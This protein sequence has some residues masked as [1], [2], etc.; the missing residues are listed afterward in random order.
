MGERVQ[1]PLR[2][3]VETVSGTLPFLGGFLRRLIRLVRVV[4]ALV[5]VVSVLRLVFLP[6]LHQR[7]IHPITRRGVTNQLRVLQQ[8]DD[9]LRRRL[10]RL[11]VEPHLVSH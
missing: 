10:K 6:G 2:K 11:M 9:L 3:L 1:N 8:G 4:S 7:G 5:R